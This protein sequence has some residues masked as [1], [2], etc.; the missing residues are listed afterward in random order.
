MRYFLSLP[1]IIGASVYVATPA[2]SVALSDQEDI[3][4]ITDINAVPGP[5][6]PDQ[7][8]PSA[9]TITRR[10]DEQSDYEPLCRVH[11]EYG[12][13]S[14]T[15]R[16]NNSPDTTKVPVDYTLCELRNLDDGPPALVCRLDNPANKRT[17]EP[18]NLP[19]DNTKREEDLPVDDESATLTDT[20]IVSSSGNN[21]S[22]SHV[23]ALEARMR[24]AFEQVMSKEP[25]L[26]PGAELRSKVSQQY[27]TNL[28]VEVASTGSK[29]MRHGSRGA[30]EVP[31]DD[32]KHQYTHRP[33]PEEF[34]D[35]AE[36]AKDGEIE[37]RGGG[38][39]KGRGKG[40]GKGKQPGPFCYLDVLGLFC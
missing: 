8:I 18:D 26:E 28:A 2:Y 7:D 6:V 31:H 10:D 12:A 34:A 36:D 30:Q 23:D 15:C 14:L 9:S 40:K 17:T 4:S 33:F 5:K 38:K 3:P 24:K 21:A 20:A 19:T 39:H 25:G 16:V 13:P 37:K 1:A 22:A 29:S 35:S 11:V 32:V 27:K